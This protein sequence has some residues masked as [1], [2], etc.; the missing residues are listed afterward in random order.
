MLI[1]DG[2][3]QI[4][5]AITAIAGAS[6]DADAKPTLVTDKMTRATEARALRVLP[7]VGSACSTGLMVVGSF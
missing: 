7:S 5:G 6:I 2:T 1:I 4:L 3:V